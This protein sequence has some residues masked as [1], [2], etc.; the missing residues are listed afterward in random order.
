VAKFKIELFNFLINQ[1]LFCYLVKDKT[2]I[3]YF[4]EFEQNPVALF[5]YSFII[6][7][8]LRSIERPILKFKTKLDRL[9]KKV[10]END[11]T[12]LRCCES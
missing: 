9:S 1:C 3:K 12:R 8:H 10:N 5:L 7:T 6:K 4:Q 2:K 11:K